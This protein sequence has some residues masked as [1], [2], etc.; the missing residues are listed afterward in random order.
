MTKSE[1]VKKYHL[2]KGFEKIDGVQHALFGNGHVRVSDVYW[3]ENGQI[4]HTGVAFSASDKENGKCGDAWDNVPPLDVKE[5][6]PLFVIKATNKESLIV[7][8]DA[9]NRAID[10]LNKEQNN[11]TT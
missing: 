4:T 10:R 9:G 8:R 6:N 7:L 2:E 1:E 5:V 11:E 3:G